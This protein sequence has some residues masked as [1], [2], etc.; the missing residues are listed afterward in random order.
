MSFKRNY[1]RKRHS[2]SLLHAH[3]VFSVKYRRRA[4]TRRAFDVLRTSMRQT[5]FVL[6]VDII[7]IE[8]DGDHL[9]I[10]IYR[11]PN[12][13]LS[14]VVQRLKGASSR[15]LRMKRLS[16]IT[17]KLWGKAFWSP[18][19]FVVSCGGAPLDTVKAYV[20]N[21][22]NP[23]RKTRNNPICSSNRKTKKPYPRTK[24]QGLRVRI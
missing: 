10:M 5:A 16:E 18:S 1:R 12:L 15:A 21:Q 2:V 20:S 23:L 24:V 3:L 11:P 19:Y 14:K 9:H 17:K 13:G 22:T 8:S 4:I 7:A 6:G